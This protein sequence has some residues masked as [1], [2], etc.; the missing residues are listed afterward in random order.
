[1]RLVTG[2]QDTVDLLSGDRV[3]FYFFSKN[4]S[5]QQEDMTSNKFRPVHSVT[6]LPRYVI[7]IRDEESRGSGFPGLFN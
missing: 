4:K 6:P 2:L 5:I 7:R 3:F 1:M